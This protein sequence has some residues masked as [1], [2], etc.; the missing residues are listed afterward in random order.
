MMVWGGIEF[1]GFTTRL[2]ETWHK[3]TMVVADSNSQMNKI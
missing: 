3:H 2:S 1:K